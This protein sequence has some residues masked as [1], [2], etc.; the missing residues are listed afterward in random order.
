MERVYEKTT[1]F[2]IDRAADRRGDH[3]HS[4]D[5]RPASVFE[6]SGAVEGHGGVGGD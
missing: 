2:H 1:R 5:Y 6:V 4:G 3:R